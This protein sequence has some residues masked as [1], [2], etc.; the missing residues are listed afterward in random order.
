MCQISEGSRGAK[1]QKCKSAK[2]QV[3]V[4]GGAG[5]DIIRLK[6]SGVEILVI[7]PFFLH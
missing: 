2:A 7:C 6:A 4:G 1:V 3:V 5:D